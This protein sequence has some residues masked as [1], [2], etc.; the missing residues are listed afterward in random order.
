[1][2]AQICRSDGTFDQCVCIQ[3]IPLPDMATGN[4]VTPVIHD[5]AMSTTS[6]GGDKRVFITSTTYVGS[7]VRTACDAAAGAASLGGTWVPWLS[8]PSG[9]AIDA[10][11]ATGPWKLLDGTLVFNNHAALGAQPLMPI[12]LDENGGAVSTFDRVWTGTSNGGVSSASNCSGWSTTANDATY[13]DPNTPS[14]WTDVGSGPCS[15]PRHVYC[16][17]N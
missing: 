5:L 3:Q 17:E 9:N 16:F 7:A 10:I 2:G 12:V 8:G 1:M 4:T 15:N 11:T 6:S 14:S 13:G